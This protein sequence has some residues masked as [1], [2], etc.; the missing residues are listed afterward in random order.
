MQNTEIQ[1]INQKFS[2]EY[3]CYVFPDQRFPNEWRSCCTA[4]KC[5][6]LEVAE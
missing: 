6:Y 3:F 4:L 5:T 1:K 2:N